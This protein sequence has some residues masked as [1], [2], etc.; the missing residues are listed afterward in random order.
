MSKTPTASLVPIF[1]T[2]ILD[3]AG[4]GLVLPVLPDLFGAT[5]G[6]GT[7]GLAY[8]FFLSLYALMQFL[9]APLLGS[10]SDRIGRKPILLAS[11]GGAAVNYAAM[12][13]LPPLWVLF[14]LRAI[15][16]VTG[17]SISVASAYLADLSTPED[18]AARFG[19]LSACFGIGFILGPVAGGLLREV[20]LNWPFAVAAGVAGLNLL[21]CLVRLPESR[22]AEP[23]TEGFDP[24]AGFREIGHFR[25]LAPLLMV[26][27]VFALV[28]E[29]GGSVW[30]FYTHQKFQW[31][32]VT[33][34]IS[35]GLFGLFHSLAQAFLIGPV[36]KR[37]GDRLAL[38]V[39]M[40]CDMAAYTAM[41]LLTDGWFVF[42]LI[43]LFC[44]GGMAPSV[45][46]AVLSRKVGEDRQ[47]QLQGVVASLASL[48][49]I[50]GPTLFLSLYFA[51]RGVFPGLVWI[52][53]AALYLV[54]L[55]VVA[56]RSA[57]EGGV[58]N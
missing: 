7:S 24:L 55:P 46:A 18:R 9:F 20:G 31:H 39:G 45:L 13:F 35:L 29:V 57:I 16:G 2:V 3:A 25:N 5:A 51:T 8:G 22:A 41:A 10:L 34:G 19:Q 48:A 49:S 56:R 38:L 52:A 54:C 32:G 50:V 15:A 1:L 44:L 58:A 4:I 43:P 53:G 6:A 27:V 11:I 23:S 17:A 14:V 21:L 30:V 36:T 37:L 40:A 28:G 26:S 12:A 42:A 47:G 33:V